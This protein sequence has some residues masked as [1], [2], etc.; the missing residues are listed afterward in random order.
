MSVEICK[1]AQVILVY[2]VRGVHGLSSGRKRRHVYIV[3]GFDLRTT[4]FV[5]QMK[6]G[7][8][9]IGKLWLPEAVLFILFS[10]IHLAL[11]EQGCG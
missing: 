2:A 9:Y 1:W 3:E 6:K 5:F 11:H 8:G 10:G 4:D 7:A